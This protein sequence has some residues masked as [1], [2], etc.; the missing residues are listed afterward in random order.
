MVSC[1][2]KLCRNNSSGPFTHQFP[3]PNFPWPVPTLFQQASSVRD[4]HLS[5]RCSPPCWDSLCFK[6]PQTALLN[7]SWSLIIQNSFDPK[8]CLFFGGNLSL[9]AELTPGRNPL[10]CLIHMHCL[11]SG[12]SARSEVTQVLSGQSRRQFLTPAEAQVITA[13]TDGLLGIP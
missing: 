12:R 5:H 9:V 10:E 4:T 3:A 7:Q 2:G 6:D 13:Q 11:L 1:G 8:I